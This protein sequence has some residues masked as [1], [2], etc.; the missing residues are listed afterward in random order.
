MCYVCV[1]LLWRGFAPLPVVFAFCGISYPRLTTDDSPSD[2]WSEDH[3]GL[4]GHH[5]PMSLPSLPL[6]TW[7]CYHLT[8]SQEERCV[9]YKIKDILRD[10]DYGHLTLITYCY[11][12]YNSPQIL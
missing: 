4:A 3:R 7:A 10:R 6:I 1:L 2:V 5:V 9:Q 12:L 8:W 11:N